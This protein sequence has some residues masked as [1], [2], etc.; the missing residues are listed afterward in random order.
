VPSTQAK[1]LA[2]G[3]ARTEKGQASVRAQA[4]VVQ[5]GKTAKKPAKGRAPLAGVA[6]CW[7]L[8][9]FILM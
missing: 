5:M 8:S 6:L 7:Y 4:N 1:G 2:G 3:E 9:A